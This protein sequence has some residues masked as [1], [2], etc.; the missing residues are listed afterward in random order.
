M[1]RRATATAVDISAAEADVSAG[2][3]YGGGEVR[4]KTASDEAGYCCWS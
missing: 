4:A 2:K 3:A 1:R